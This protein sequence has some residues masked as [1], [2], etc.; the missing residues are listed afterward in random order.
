MVGF[1]LLELISF[2]A[3]GR[4][5]QLAGEALTEVQSRFRM[6]E[7]EAEEFLRDTSQAMETC[8]RLHILT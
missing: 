7:M 4:E 1:K 8:S 2:N 6:H 3:I 5:V